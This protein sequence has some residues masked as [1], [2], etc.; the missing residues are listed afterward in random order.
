L[1]QVDGESPSPGRAVNAFQDI[2]ADC[3]SAT[4]NYVDLAAT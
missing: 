3:C 1:L 4:S 2:S